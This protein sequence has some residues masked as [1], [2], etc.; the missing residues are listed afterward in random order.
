M[1]LVA[2]AS[3]GAGVM[4]GKNS[5][6]ASCIV[7]KYPN[8]LARSC[9]NHRLDLAAAETFSEVRAVNHL[10]IFDKLYTLYSRSPKTKTEQSG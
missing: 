10:E 8:G 4:L 1:T 5:G 6:V 7:K 3:D 9:L 2:F